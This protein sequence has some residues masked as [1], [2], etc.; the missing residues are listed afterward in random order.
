MDPSLA[1]VAP[2]GNI[3][4]SL[5]IDKNY[6]MVEGGGCFEIGTTFHREEEAAGGL[7]FH[8]ARIFLYAVGA[9]LSISI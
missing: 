9:G 2:G 3:A 6:I 1:L 7:W 4:V 8:F 5:R